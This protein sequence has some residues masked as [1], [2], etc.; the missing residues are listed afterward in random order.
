MPLFSSRHVRRCRGQQRVEVVRPHLAARGVAAAVVEARLD[1]LL[2][3]L[4]YAV[5]GGLSSALAP[6]FSNKRDTVFQH[7][8]SGRSIVEP[9]APRFCE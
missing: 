3:G 9:N 4:R 1:A 2:H 7:C 6:K 8:N 5:E